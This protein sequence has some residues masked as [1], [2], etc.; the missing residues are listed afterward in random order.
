MKIKIVC[1]QCF[2]EIPETEIKWGSGEGELIVPVCSNCLDEN[3]E[4][5]VNSKITDLQKRVDN[6]FREV[7]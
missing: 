3:V 7:L 6:L 1:G 2:N 4:K 5:T